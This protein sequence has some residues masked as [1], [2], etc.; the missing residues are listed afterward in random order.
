MSEMFMGAE[1]EIELKKRCLTCWSLAPIVKPH[2]CGHGEFTHG[3]KLLCEHADVCKHVEEGEPS[4][5]DIVNM[6]NVER[7]GRR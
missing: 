4:V 6:V 3:G 1:L 7:M 2:V 5:S